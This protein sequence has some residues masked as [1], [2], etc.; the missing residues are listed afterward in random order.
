[1]TVKWNLPL[2][3]PGGELLPHMSARR[4]TEIIDAVFE[5]AGGPEK[6]SAW[7]RKSD[8]NYGDFIL[9]L[10]GKGAAR[11]TNMEVTA[12]DG[13]ESL[14]KKLDQRE[15]EREANVIDSTA[16]LVGSS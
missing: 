9:K 7:V 15:R 12:S 11:V 4:R 2:A 13:I 8:E 6:L 3:M 14:L 16:V 1:M 5:D 10:W